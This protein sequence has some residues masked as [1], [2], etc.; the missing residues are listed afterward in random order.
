MIDRYTR[1]EMGFVW[2]PEAKF[3]KMMEVEIA[4]AE[5][6]AGMGMIPRNA[7]KEIRKKARFSVKRIGEIEKETKHDVIAFVS[8]VAENVGPAGR[9]VHYGMTSS[10]VLD[11]AFS[12]QVRDAGKVLMTGFDR[13]EK[14]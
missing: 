10:D 3:G 1:P 13:L 8:N 7:A 5:V 11:T 4:V 14:A 2:E 12:L 9:Y 6:Q